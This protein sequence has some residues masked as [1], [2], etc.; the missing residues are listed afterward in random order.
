M[1][2]NA[3]AKHVRISPRKARLVADVVRGLDVVE[4][5]DKLGLLTKKAV[6]FIDK[7]LN[8]AL[9]NAKHNLELEE[10]NLYIKSITVD[11]GP[12]LYRWMPRAF[13]RA[14][15]LRKRTSIIKIT[16]A[17]KVP[18]TKKAKDK[19]PAKIETVKVD[20]KPASQVTSSK[21]E[22]TEKESKTGAE[23]KAEEKFEGGKRSGFR[24]AQQQ[25][26]KTNKNDKGLLKKMFRRKSGM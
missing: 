16:L 26:E 6:K 23:E 10:S 7:V 9:A 2:V 24:D 14:T 15:Q 22:S 1:E 20:E 17:E 11:D 8:S 19:V 5:K 21:V 3:K 13:G 4:A 18:T 25:Q 12:I